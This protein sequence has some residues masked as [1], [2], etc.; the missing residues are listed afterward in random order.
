MVIIFLSVCPSTMG[1]TGKN[2]LGNF[3]R[4]QSLNGTSLNSK[5]K[6]PESYYINTYS[7]SVSSYNGDFLFTINEGGIVFNSQWERIDENSIIGSNREVIMISDSIYYS[8]YARSGPGS[9]YSLYFNIINIVNNTP[10]VSESQL[11]I[12]DSTGEC[13]GMAAV[14]DTFGGQWVIIRNGYNSF[15]T[16]YFDSSC[17]GCKVRDTV[18]NFSNEFD[19]EGTYNSLRA[20]PSGN[21]IISTSMIDRFQPNGMSCFQIDKSTGKLSLLWANEPMLAPRINNDYMSSFGLTESYDY[22]FST[23]DSFFLQF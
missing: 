22:L 18:L 11:I 14:Q 23:N 17:V 20:S 4:I 13:Y 12:K 1:Q 9:H 2:F 7:F 3:G 5:L 16:V 10:V 15:K 6:F 19:T 21:L 8:V